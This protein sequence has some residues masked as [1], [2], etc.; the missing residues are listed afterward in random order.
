MTV[1]NVG[2]LTLPL[3]L[4]L[5]SILL[6]PHATA[7]YGNAVNTVGVIQVGSAAKDIQDTW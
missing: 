6:P 5:I 4:V 3:I 7:P 1:A 2:I